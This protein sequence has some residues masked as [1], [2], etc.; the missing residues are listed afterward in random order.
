MKRQCSN[1]ES[2]CICALLINDKRV[3]SA[4]AVS[5]GQQSATL[6]FPM[7]KGPFLCLFLI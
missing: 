2:L 3:L 1:V 6:T 4:T 7:L 5:A